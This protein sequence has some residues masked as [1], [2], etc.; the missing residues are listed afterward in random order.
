M[1]IGARDWGFRLEDITVPVHVWHGD[2]D[3]NIP[4]AQGELQAELIPHATLH[5]CPGE[6]HAIYV[7][8]MPEILATLTGAPA[9]RRM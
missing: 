7:D 1:A 5:R 4:I 9:A 3:R 6:A 2:R 8:H